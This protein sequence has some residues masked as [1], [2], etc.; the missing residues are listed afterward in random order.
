M[1][2]KK[3][4]KKINKFHYQI[5]TFNLNCWSGKTIYEYVSDGYRWIEI[6]SKISIQLGVDNVVV[7]RI[8]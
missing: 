2:G 6:C 5:P 4:K 7:Q 8:C 3:R 1:G